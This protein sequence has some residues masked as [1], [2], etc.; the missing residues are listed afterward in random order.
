MR[1]YYIVMLRTPE[2]TVMSWALYYSRRKAR[3]AFLRANQVNPDGSRTILLEDGRAE[4]IHPGTDLNVVLRFLG[5]VRSGLRVVVGDP[6][7]SMYHRKNFRNFCR[8]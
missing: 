3:R 2:G 1:P 8:E 4:N 5:E 6:A 7:F